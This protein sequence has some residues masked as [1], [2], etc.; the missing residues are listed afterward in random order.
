VKAGARAAFIDRDGVINADHGYVFE[1]DRL[2]LLPGV[3]AALRRLQQAGWLLIVV[4]NQSGIARGFYSQAEYDALTRHLHDLLARQGVRLD[5]VYHCPHL[6]DAAVPAYRLECDCRK[7]RPGMILRGIAEFGIDPARSMLFGDKPSDIE[8]GRAAGIGWCC[9]VAAEGTD[10]G[11]ADGVAPDLAR[12]VE[13]GL[14]G[15]GP[16]M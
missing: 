16:A 8:A 7:P 5:A 2:E 11:D 13:A 15:P 1:A 14:P 10:R 9:L 6:P 3:T 12:G 4:T